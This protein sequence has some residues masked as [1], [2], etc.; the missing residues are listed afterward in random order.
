MHIISF[1]K[2][3]LSIFDDLR[4]IET[5]INSLNANLK[6][7]LYTDSNKYFGETF[8]YI[9]DFL[10]RIRSDPELASDIFVR[11]GDYI[12]SIETEYKALIINIVE[13]FYE[14]FN[15]TPNLRCEFLASIT[16]F[17]EVVFINVIEI[18]GR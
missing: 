14:N 15:N 5:N 18:N 11:I 13:L 1:F 7:I 9:K 6:Q 4:S 2:R 10:Y 16:R 8:S 3:K 17:I 12:E